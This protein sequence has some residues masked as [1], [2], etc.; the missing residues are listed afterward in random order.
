ML[1]KIQLL[2]V[3]TPFQGIYDVTDSFPFGKRRTNL[4]HLISRYFLLLAKKYAILGLLSSIAK[5]W[6]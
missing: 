1:S 2:K 5:S 4:F 6:Q 3:K